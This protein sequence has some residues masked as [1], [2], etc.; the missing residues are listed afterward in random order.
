MRSNFSS[1]ISVIFLSKVYGAHEGSEILFWSAALVLSNTISE[2]PVRVIQLSFVTVRE[3]QRHR[4]NFLYLHLMDIYPFIKFLIHY[5]YLSFR[6]CLS[7]TLGLNRK[8]LGSGP[9]G[10]TWLIRQGFPLETNC[11]KRQYHRSR[12]QSS[13]SIITSCVSLTNLYS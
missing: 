3:N 10:R 9:E 7:L 8:G 1:E 13:V 2:R 4:H 12:S 5:S 6:V 11:Y